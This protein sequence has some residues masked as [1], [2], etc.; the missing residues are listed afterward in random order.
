MNFPAIAK[1]TYETLKDQ[2]FFS[3]I[4]QFII[5]HLKKIAS[6]LERARF[7]HNVVDDY[8]SE[9]FKHPM[10]L[11]LS[12]CKK[13]CSAC[14][15]TQVSITADEA[16][17]LVSCIHE[18]VKIDYSALQN[19]MKAANSSKDFYKLSY[20]DRKCVFLGPENSCLVYLDR[21]SVCRT[22]MV[23]GDALQCSTKEG[24]QSFKE[25]RLVKTQQ[26]D[27]ALMGAFLESHES[28]NLSY[29]LGRILFK[30]KPST[31]PKKMSVLKK[32]IFIDRDL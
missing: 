22:N 4:T 10:V 17:L 16:E 24:E 27:M 12:P 9:V 15:H 8:N 32:S 14:C 30:N 21:P 2:T 6:P 31:P 19:Q 28:G 23:M 29:M 3:N 13:G 7:I 5:K 18:G 20:N 11:Q 1:Q 26:A 25:H